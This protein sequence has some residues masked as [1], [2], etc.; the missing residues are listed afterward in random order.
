MNVVTSVSPHN[1]TPDL[2]TGLTPLPRESESSRAELTTRLLQEAAATDD[3]LEI[4]R[5]QDEVVVLNMA[6]AQSIAARYRG[7]G[8]SS[9]DLLQVGY[10]GLLKAARGFD[11]SNGADFLSYA[12]PTV[13]G[14]V[15]RYFRDLGWVVR[16]PRRIQ[17]LQSQISGATRKLR[18]TLGRSPKPREV[19]QY[20]EAPVEDVIEAL[21]ADRCFAPTS[22]DQPVGADGSSTLGEFLS[23]E[24]HD[25][26]AAEARVMLAPAVRSLCDRDRRIL[27]LRFFRQFTQAQIAEDIGVTQMQVSRLLSRILTD[28]RGRLD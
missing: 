1:A 24:E 15:R 16:P 17:E 28:L 13:R 18:Q 25:M 12:I 20:L 14:E 3:E 19:A 10:M 9:E 23:G 11:P 6:V 2:L 27:Y 4:K 21:G 5:L 22:L 26:D 7:K 8:V